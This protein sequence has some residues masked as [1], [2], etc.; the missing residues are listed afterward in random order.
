M[1]MSHIETAK[2]PDKIMVST[3]KPRKGKRTLRL[4]RYS[5]LELKRL[6]KEFGVKQEE[7]ASFMG[8]ARSMISLWEKESREQEEGKRVVIEEPGLKRL[9]QFGR[10]FTQKAGY[11][12]AFW[13]DPDENEQEQA[14]EY[15]DSKP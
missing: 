6:R 10:F 12:V 8:V 14:P 11:K 5:P 1:F 9:K 2:K 13:A 4:I 7:L 15:W 3:V